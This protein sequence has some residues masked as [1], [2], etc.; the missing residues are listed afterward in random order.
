VAQ[1]EAVLATEVPTGTQ[2]TELILSFDAPPRDVGEIGSLRGRL[3][4]LV[5][6]RQAKFRFD[7]LSRAAGKSQRIGGVEVRVDA[8]RRN[9]AIWEVH[10]RLRL[11]EDNHALESHRGWAYQNLSYLVDQNGESI[12]NAGLETTLQRPNEVG[13]AYFFDL[14]D[15]VDGLT[16]V[17][18]TPAAIVELPVDYEI[19]DILLP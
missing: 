13:V 16:W 15:G 6:G 12:D 2:A 18:E 8:V 3:R 5:P 14:P 7:D 1:P 17:Y 19:K 9:N 4:A 11:D 10:M